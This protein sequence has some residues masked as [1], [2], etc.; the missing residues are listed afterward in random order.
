M[1]RKIILC[2][3]LNIQM[4]NIHDM[5]SISLPKYICAINTENC[6]KIILVTKIK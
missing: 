5:N 2:C 6:T 4:N 1:K 3:L